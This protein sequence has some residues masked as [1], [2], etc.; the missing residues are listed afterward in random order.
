LVESL[1]LVLAGELR[2]DLF[3]ALATVYAGQPRGPVRI[4]ADTNRRIAVFRG[5]FPPENESTHKIARA[6]V[7]WAKQ[8]ECSL[9]VTSSGLF[10]VEGQE[11]GDDQVLAA[12]NDAKAKEKLR[13]SGIAPLDQAVVTGLAGSLLLEGGEAGISVIAFLVQAHEG[14]PDYEAGLKLAEALANVV[15]EAECEMMGIKAQAERSEKALRDLRAR[16]IP[17]IYR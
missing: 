11:G 15:P 5:D 10:P 2:S 6:M 7:S 4:Y 3:P 1:K 17:E 13:T 16:L 12:A 9:I 8:K 14:S